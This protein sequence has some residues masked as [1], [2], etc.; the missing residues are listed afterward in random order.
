MSDYIRLAEAP[1][2][3]MQ[4][5]TCSACGVDLDNDGDGWVCPCCGT[6][7]SN[8]AG[9][10]DTGE[11]YAAWAGEEATGP[12]VSKDEAVR[13]G[14]YQARMERHRIL[15]DFCP[16]PKRPQVKEGGPDA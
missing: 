13:W 8:N 15:P 14:D 7:W 9:D 10:G 11:L 12:I 16:K 6:A 4:Y 5:P 1:Q 3:C 2:W